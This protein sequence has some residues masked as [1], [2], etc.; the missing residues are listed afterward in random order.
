MKH[1][2]TTVEKTVVQEDVIAVQITKDEFAT[3]A[4]K[5]CAKIVADAP[6]ENF[7]LA[8]LIGTVLADFCALLAHRM[9]DDVE[10]EAEG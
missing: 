6:E 4:A 7:V 3:L 8:M 1:V 5:E 9:F 2:K 10:E